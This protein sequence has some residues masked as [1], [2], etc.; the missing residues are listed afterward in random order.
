MNPRR[1]GGFGKI[2]KMSET[3]WEK[4]EI[5]DE[6]LMVFWRSFKETSF[7]RASLTSSFISFWNFGICKRID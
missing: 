7:S 5:W 3:I 6:E 4:D 1:M 2:G